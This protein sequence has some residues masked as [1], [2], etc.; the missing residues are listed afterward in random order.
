MAID[1][2]LL[3]Q[4]LAGRDPKESF[5]RDGLI[6]ELKKALSERML[7]AE[8]DDHLVGFLDRVLNSQLDTRNTGRGSN[9]RFAFDDEG[10]GP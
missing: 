8:L 3:D 4:L 2:E 6:D 7:A 1:K 9:R 10:T 5:A